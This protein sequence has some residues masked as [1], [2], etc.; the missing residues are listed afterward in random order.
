MSIYHDGKKVA[1][2]VNIMNNQYA[3]P[4]GTIIP[5]GSNNIPA[6]YLICDGSEVLKTD[7]PEL[8]GVIGNAFGTVTDSTKFK[9]PDLRN[10]FIQGANSNT[11]EIKEAGL[12]N[13][14]GELGYLKGATEG[15]YWQG[16][17]VNTGAF[18]SSQQNVKA[19]PH[20]VS[21][22]PDS[23]AVNN[24][25]MA[26]FRASDSNDIYGNSSTVQPPAVCI[27]YIIKAK[28]S[29]VSSEAASLI[30]DSSDATDR[31]WSSSKVIDSTIP[32]HIMDAS[33]DIDLNDYKEIGYYTPN[34]SFSTGKF[35]HNILNAPTN[36]WLPAGGF[37][38]EV[39]NFDNT[40]NVNW[41]T[42][43]L[44]AYVSTNE[45]APIYV[46]TFFYKNADSGSVYTP[47][48]RIAD[49]NDNVISSEETW[50]SQKINEENREVYSTDEVKTNKVWID[51][52]PI[53]RKVTTQTIT[54]LEATPIN[55]FDTSLVDSVISI[56][57]S[58]KQPTGN[59]TPISFYNKATDGAYVYTSKERNRFIL[60]ARELGIGDVIL[61]VEY[62]KTTD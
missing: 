59:I 29:D 60:Y 16:I 55:D 30:D 41:Y 4:I 21:F 11:G 14:T 43:V 38:L 8:Y 5:F 26:I 28:Q 54:T 47:W 6:G 46:R 1:Y 10:K 32:Y 52:K 42:Q 61:I 51:G 62:T 48:R 27:N 9:L 18:K 37:G 3:M 39:K 20:A 36:G 53:Y 19:S 15:N 31:V 12:P 44:Y 25:C 13:I 17:N 49:I 34:M 35:T 2:D 56:Y 57:G 24:P 22:Q 7:Y 40:N 45:C 23:A 50:S 33:K 58:I